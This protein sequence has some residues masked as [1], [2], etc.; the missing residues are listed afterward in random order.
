MSTRNSHLAVVGSGIAGLFS[1]LLAAEAGLRVT[2]VTK[3]ALAQSNTHFAQGGICAVLGPED[4]APGDTVEAHIADT[5]KAGAGQCNPDAVR[6][7]CEEAC[8]DIGALERFGVVFDRDADT[9]RRALGLE[10]AHSAARILH[11]GGDATGAAIADGLIRAVRDAAALGTVTILENT[12]VRDLVLDAGQVTGVALLAPDGRP[13]TLEAGAVLLAS[14]GAGQL[15]DFTTNP[16]VATADGLAA[17]WRAGAAVADLEYFQFHPTALAVGGNFL[18]SEAV[19]GAGAVLRD[20]HGTAFMARYHPEGDLAPRDVVSRSI[21][22]HLRSLHAEPG[23]TVFLDATGVE[24][25]HGAGYLARRFP[26]IDARTR[27][28]GFDWTREYLP[29]T[30]AAHYWM[31]GIASNLHGQTSLPGLYAAGEAACTGVH[32]A[33]RLASNSLLEGLVFGRRAV[34]SFTAGSF[35]L[36]PGTGAKTRTPWP[37]AATLDDGAVVPAVSS[38]APGDSLLGFDRESLRR[39]MGARAGV[40]RNAAGL[41]EAAAQLASWRRQAEAASKEFAEAGGPRPATQAEAELDNLLLVAELLVHAAL[42]RENSVGGHFRSD[43]PEPPGTGRSPHLWV[44][45]TSAGSAHLPTSLPVLE[46]ETV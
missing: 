4:A 43:F 39:L 44:R 1:T 9:G 27:E 21:A 8:A 24:A 36:W 6:I 10:G 12:F 11:A 7:L 14:G 46:S 33:N 18:I 38:A 41:G 31:G 15:F 22:A 17:A 3:G 40:V 45:D 34:E 42:T 37:E 30:P 5:L 29:V 32:G 2:L 16:S 26:T 20:S 19:R 13:W 23:A 28:L 25:S 35:G